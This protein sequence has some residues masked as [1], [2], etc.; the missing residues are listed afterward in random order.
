MG[1]LESRWYRFGE[2]YGNR[3]IVSKI[4]KT[5]NS[6]TAYLTL[7]QCGNLVATPLANAKKLQ[8]DSVCAECT[9]GFYQKQLPADEIIYSIF[10]KSKEEN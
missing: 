3:I 9:K 1:R 4:T 5:V 7:C 8:G 6:D 2:R 10:F